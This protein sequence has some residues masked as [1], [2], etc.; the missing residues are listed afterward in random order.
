MKVHQSS[1]DETRHFSSAC[2]HADAIGPICAGVLLGGP[3]PAAG[4]DWSSGG[5]SWE[6][7]NTHV[8]LQSTELQCLQLISPLCVFCFYTE[9]CVLATTVKNNFLRRSRLLNKG[10]RF[11]PKASEVLLCGPYSRLSDILCVR[12]QSH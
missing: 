3:Q 10:Q 12:L 9:S 11:V 7:C 5:A 4:R 2:F 1:G 6:F 8:W